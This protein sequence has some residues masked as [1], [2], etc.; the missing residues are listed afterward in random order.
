MVADVQARPGSGAVAAGRHDRR[1]V[2]QVAGPFDRGDQH[3]AG[4]VDLDGA[5]GPAE[6]IDDI[7]SVEV[8]LQGERPAAERPRVGHGVLA[9]CDGHR[10]QVFGALAGL[11][12]EALGP[13][14]DVH[15]VGAVA[16]RIAVLAA[17]TGE[18]HA[19]DPGPRTPFH[20]AVDQ[21]RLG[22]PGCHRRGRLGDQVARRL[23]AEID[24]EREAHLRQPE[25][26]R[27]RLGRHRVVHHHEARDAVDVGAA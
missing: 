26:G 14:R 2:R 20:G 19:A 5:V 27:D 3:G 15:E 16:D 23:T 21:H 8:L 1:R 12:E 6:G 9:L 4:P 7:G 10:S 24:V 17:P 22:L 11:G 13:H 25:H 18:F